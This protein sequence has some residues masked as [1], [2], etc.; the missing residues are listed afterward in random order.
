MFSPPFVFGIRP[1][2]PLPNLRSRKCT[3]VYKDI[4]VGVLRFVF[5]PFLISVYDLT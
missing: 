4:V 2:K 1:Q 5:D 3:P